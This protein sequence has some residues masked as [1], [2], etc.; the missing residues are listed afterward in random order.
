MVCDKDIRS[1]SADILS[2]LNLNPHQRHYTE[3]PGPDV[4]RPVPHA[5]AHA[6]HTSQ[7]G[8]RRGKNGDDKKHRNGDAYLIDAVE[9]NHGSLWFYDANLHIFCRAAK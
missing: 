2:T 8:D 6:E 7:Y 5:T 4:T 9:N 3:N 1:I